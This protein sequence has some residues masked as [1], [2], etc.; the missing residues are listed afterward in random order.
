MEFHHFEMK[1]KDYINSF[2]GEHHYQQCDCSFNTLFLWQHAYSTMWAVEDNILFVR[3]GR[4]DM[5]YFMPPFE[6][7]GASFVHGLEIISEY[8]ILSKSAPFTVN[9]APLQDR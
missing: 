3:A 4:G 6:G 8:F 2:F 1:D 9:L 5:A 7:K